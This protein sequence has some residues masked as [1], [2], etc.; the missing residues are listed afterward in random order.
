MSKQ[1]R[2]AMDLNGTNGMDQCLNSLRDIYFKMMEYPGLRKHFYEDVPC[3]SD[4]VECERVQLM[5]EAMADVLETGLMATRRI[6]ETESFDDWRDYCRFILERSPVLRD[7]TDEH[8]MWWPELR[9]VR[10]S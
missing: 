1:V 5:A 9:Q 7:L 3:P 6:P 2:M 8:P 10:A 4:E